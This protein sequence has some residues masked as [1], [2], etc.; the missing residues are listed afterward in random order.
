MSDAIQP[1][2]NTPTKITVEDLIA[3]ESA[4]LA[5]L[6]EEFN[7]EGSRILQAHNSM[8][9]GHNSSGTHTSHTSAMKEDVL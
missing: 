3:S 6:A 9:S 7:H 4:V 8:T 1:T 2:Q 5:R